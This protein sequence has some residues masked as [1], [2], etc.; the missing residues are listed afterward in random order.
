MKLQ[1][2]KLK[3]FKSYPDQETTIDLSFDGIKLLVGEN[4][5]GKSTFFDAIMWGIYGKNKDGVD[6]V[7]NIK[8]KLWEQEEYSAFYHLMGIKEDCMILRNPFKHDSKLC[9]IYAIPFETFLFFE[10]VEDQ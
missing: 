9:R 4:G 8:T 5:D 10:H 1:Y 2:V 7:V 3:N 6:G